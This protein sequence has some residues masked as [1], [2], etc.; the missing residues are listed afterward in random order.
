[1]LSRQSG[2]LVVYRSGVEIGRARVVFHGN[3]PIGTH[4]LLMVEGAAQTPQRYNPRRDTQ[5]WVEVDIAGYGN[6]G[7]TEP[8]VSLAQRIEVPPEFIALVTNLLVPGDTVLVTDE[9]ITPATSGPQLDVI[10]SEPPEADEAP[11]PAP[12]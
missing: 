5:H 8:D 2:R 7:G 9:L 6:R 12:D 11:G 10:N 1:V 3:E 4:V